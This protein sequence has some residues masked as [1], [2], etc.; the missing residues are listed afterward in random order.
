MSRSVIRTSV[1][2][3][4]TQA[5][6]QPIPDKSSFTVFVNSKQGTISGPQFSCSA[7]GILRATWLTIQEWHSSV[8]SNP[9]SV[10]DALAHADTFLPWFLK[11]SLSIA[12]WQASWAAPHSSLPT[13][14]CAH[15]SWVPINSKATNKAN[16]KFLITHLPIVLLCIYHI[17]IL[18]Q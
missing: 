14:P 3:A 13:S 11:S 15:T 8:I 7:T 12:S 2:T 6:N 5:S 18:T 17:C 1:P 4:S 10:F 9:A 16:N